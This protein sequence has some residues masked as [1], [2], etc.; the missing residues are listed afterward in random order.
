MP[1]LYKLCRLSVWEIV[2]PI[3]GSEVGSGLCL[4]GA[5]NKCVDRRETK[6]NWQAAC[7]VV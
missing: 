1:E 4:A 7:G 5:G 6:S 3:S 2:R